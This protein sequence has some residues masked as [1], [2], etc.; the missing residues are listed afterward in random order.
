[1]SSPIR[2]VGAVFVD[3]NRFLACRKAPGKS[4]AGMWEFPGGKIE[5]GETPKQA[6]AREIKE[7]LSVS[8]HVGD[9]VTTTVYEYDF[10]TI[11]LTTFLCT[12]ESGELVLSDH[13][14]TRWV[15]RT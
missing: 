5:E 3:G 8:A 7:E 9:Q 10:A 1:M 15:T 2:V 6:L 12:K 4:L 14:A 13:D 11:E